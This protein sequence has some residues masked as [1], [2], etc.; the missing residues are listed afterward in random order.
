LEWPF[1]DAFHTIAQ[2]QG[3]SVNGLAGQI[4]A[5]RGPDLGLAS[6]IRL[7]VLEHYK[8]IAMRDR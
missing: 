7:F 3:Q 4:D 5:G 1:W 8:S 6:A 2:E